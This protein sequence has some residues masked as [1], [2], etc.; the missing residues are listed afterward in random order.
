MPMAMPVD[1]WILT[2]GHRLKLK[3]GFP[4]NYSHDDIVVQ[5]ENWNGLKALVS[6]YSYR[7]SFNSFTGYYLLSTSRMRAYVFYII[8]YW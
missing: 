4:K 2:R 1:P 6:Y 5:H 7:Y 8:V 3:Y